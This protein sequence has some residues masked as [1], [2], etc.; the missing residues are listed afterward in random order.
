M[1]RKIPTPCLPDLVRRLCAQRIHNGVS[2][3]R[4]VAIAC[5]LVL[6]YGGG[7]LP[8]FRSFVLMNLLWFLLVGVTAGWL[9]GWMRPDRGAAAE[10]PV[11]AVLK[12]EFFSLGQT[13]P[14]TALLAGPSAPRHGM[15]SEAVV[16]D[17]GQLVGR[18]TRSQRLSRYRK[19]SPFNGTS[20]TVSTVTPGGFG[21]GQTPR[22]HDAGGCAATGGWCLTPTPPCPASFGKGG[23]GIEQRSADRIR[24]RASARRSRKSL[25]IS[26]LAR[27]PLTRR[28]LSRAPASDGDRQ[29][30]RRRSVP[31]ARSRACPP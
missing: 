25:K 27:H 24:C 23:Q 10:P 13:G 9:A 11:R 8:R 31:T 5:R 29:T 2:P 28:S 16:V 18:S 26:P 6:G 21:A 20:V 30:R 15:P 14:E 17:V 1:R 3:I 4:R 19:D 12:A 7:D 22:G